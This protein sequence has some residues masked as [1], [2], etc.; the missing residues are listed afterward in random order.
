VIFVTT[1]TNAGAAPFDR[2]L[3][4][5]E[6]LCRREHVVV[7][8]GASTLRPAG[9]TC[10]DYL[11]VDRFE[12][13]VQTAR[14][15]VTHA[16]VGSILVAMRH[17]KRPVVV[18]RLAR[19][20]EHVDD[21][22]LELARRLADIGAVTLVE[23]PAALEAAVFAEPGRALSDRLAADGGLAADLA[24]YLWSVVGAGAS[25]RAHAA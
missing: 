10:V 7:Q 16:G 17:G 15:V 12:Q 4:H 24:D 9:A 8:L 25:P 23:E 3:Q 19:Y 13:L 22:Q 1:G 6:P 21:H 2:L 20:G 11:P 14:S 5:V 18:P